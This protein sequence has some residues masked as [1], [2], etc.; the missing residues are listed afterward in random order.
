MSKNIAISKIAGSLSNFITDIGSITRKPPTT[1][2]TVR[3]RNNLKS[4]TN[5]KQGEHHHQ[6][7]SEP[8]HH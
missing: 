4:H 1:N 3:V 7:T 5:P 6:V 2:K 8:L